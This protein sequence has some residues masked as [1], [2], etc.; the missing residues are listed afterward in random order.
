MG[1]E[2]HAFTRFTFSKWFGWL[3]YPVAMAQTGWVLAKRRPDVVVAQNPSIVLAWQAALLRPLFRY[4]LLIDLHTHFVRPT[5]LAKLIYGFLNGYSL[6][7]CNAVIVTNEAYRDEIAKKT[8]QAVLVL[9]DKVPV[10]ESKFTRVP[11]NGRSILYICTFS[12]DEPWTEVLEAA[13]MLS[14]DTTIYISGRSPIAQSSAPHNVVLTGYLPRD[15]YENLLRSVDGVMVLTTAQDNLMCGGYEAVAAGKP[16]VLSDTPALRRLFTKGAVFT[17][18]RR[19]AI[20]ESIRTL[21]GDEQRLR[22]DIIALGVE[23]RAD[24]LCLWREVLMVAGID[25]APK[26]N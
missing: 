6:R 1:A 11:L 20:A 18:N 12:S 26:I 8:I 9:P 10:F 4:R 3:R 23:M 2:Y 24:W 21:E 7:N 5:G 14:A 19:E 25:P 13:P 15:D 22:N 16:I 17:E